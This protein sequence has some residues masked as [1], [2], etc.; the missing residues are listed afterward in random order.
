MR[1][2]RGNADAR[3]SGLHKSIV[4]SRSPLRARCLFMTVMSSGAVAKLGGEVGEHAGNGERG[5]G[6]FVGS[7]T[8]QPLDRL[9]DGYQRESDDGLLAVAERVVVDTS[10]VPVLVPDVPSGGG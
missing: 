4:T 5:D 2:G 9:A 3:D 8:R 1:T 10:P 7:L 6:Q